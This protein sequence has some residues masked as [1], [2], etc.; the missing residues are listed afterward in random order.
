MATT[1]ATEM[2]EDFDLESFR[3]EVTEFLQTAWVKAG[4]RDPTAFRKAAVERGYLYRAIP[5]QYG[6]SGQPA[7]PMKAH[8]IREEFSRVRA[9]REIAG[10]GPG[11][12]APTLLVAG[13]DWQKEM[14]IAKTLSGEIRWAQG[15]SEPGAGSDLAAL[16]TTAVLDGDEWVINGQKVWTSQ[17]HNATHMFALVRTEPDAP[18]H[19]GISY[20]L[21]RMDQPGV[22]VRPLKQITGE[23]EFNEVFFDDARTPKD[24]IVGKRGEGWLVSRQTLVFERNH[25]SGADVTEGFFERLVQL[26]RSMTVDGRPAI[27]D[28]LIRDE[29][30]R[31]QGMVAAHKANAVQ[32]LYHAV[33]GE[34]GPSAIGPINKLYN[35]TIVERI[36]FCA[37][38]IIGAKAMAEPVE[39]APG[40]GRWVKQ[41]MNSIAAQIGG[42]TSNMQRNAIA[43]RG[44]GLPRD[45]AA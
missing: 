7:D 41:Y 31:L 34:D 35:S 15:Y 22:T 29:L 21:L 23:A 33:R 39:G 8:I 4:D 45:D 5:R 37:Q 17:A 38:N 20:L 25:I 27:Q 18:K 6:G 42:G 2:R 9:P 3:R 24:W 26:A 12:V 28:P 44:L 10:N 11:M 40:A 30:G 16:R 36:A 43:E 19:A 13:E 32:Q 14:F 1:V